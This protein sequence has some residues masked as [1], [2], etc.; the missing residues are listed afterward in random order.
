L[1]NIMYIQSLCS[2]V[3]VVVASIGA[4]IFATAAATPLEFRGMCDASA[5]IALDADHF[6]VADDERNVLQ[7]FHRSGGA[8]LSEIALFDFLGTDADKESDIE[9]ATRVGDR[10]FW[11]S[12]HGRNKSGV[13]Q[14]RRYRFFAT[15]VAGTGSAAVVTPAGEPAKGILAALLEAPQ[16]EPLGLK[17]ASELA[18]EAPNGLNIEGLA[19]A[20]D[21][22]LLVGFRNPLI[23]G[24]ALAV[25][26]TNPD[27]TANGAPP[28]FGDPVLLDLGNRG[29]RSW[30]RIGSSYLVVAGPT[31]DAG[32]FALYRWSGRPEDKPVQLAET[33]L[34]ALKPEALFALPGGT[35]IGLLSDDGGLPSPAGECKDLPQDRQRFRGM[36]LPTP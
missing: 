23:D 34:G 2:A 12:S 29:I 18:P 27:D 10:I 8:A 3:A 20:D 16:L 14:K 1:E 35:E 30:E 15:D 26:L 36:F 4:T 22:H 24:K 19:A 7:V 32:E 31:A 5:A 33:E 6:V 13:E 9:A 28:S 11:I 21:G 25:P 17:Q